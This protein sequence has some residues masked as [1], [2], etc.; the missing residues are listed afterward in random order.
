MKRVFIPILPII[1]TSQLFAI[2]GFGLQ[3]GENIFSVEENFPPMSSGLV[4]ITNGAFNDADTYGGY[5]YLDML[6]VVDLEVDFSGQAKTYEIQFTNNA[7]TMDPLDFGWASTNLYITVRKKI[8]GLNIP[9]LA[10]AKLFAGGG[11]NMHATT[12]LASEEM[13]TDLLGGDI[14]TGDVSDLGDKLKEYLSEEDN[15]ITSSGFHLQGGLQFKLLIVDSFIFYRHVF[16]EDV[17][18]DTKSFGGLNIRL[19]IGF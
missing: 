15:Y 6:P 1:I 11:Y 17:I 3:L 5:I 14:I 10:K 19:G 13:I 12:P 8:F 9:F 16:V 7:G 18:P 4:Q 2:V